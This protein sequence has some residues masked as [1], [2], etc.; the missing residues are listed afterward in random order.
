MDDCDDIY[1][2][3]HAI[4]LD[5]C[6]IESLRPENWPHFEFDIEDDSICNDL[7][8]ITYSSYYV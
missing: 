5:I 1:L 3:S 7:W 8:T 6:H 4:L 2:F